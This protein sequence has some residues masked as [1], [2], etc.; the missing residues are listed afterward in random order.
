MIG[1]V[2]VNF[3]AAILI[4]WLLLFK[5]GETYMSGKWCKTWAILS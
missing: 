2:V 4:F 1:G 5:Y 3:L